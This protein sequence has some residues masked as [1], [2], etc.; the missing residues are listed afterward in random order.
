MKKFITILI[1]AVLSFSSCKDVD[2][3]IEDYQEYQEQKD[4]TTDTEDT[5]DT[6]TEEEETEPVVIIDIDINPPGNPEEDPEE[7]TKSYSENFNGTINEQPLNLTWQEPASIDKF[8]QDLA[9]YYC[10]TLELGGFSSWRLPTK[11]EL[12]SLIEPNLSPTINEIFESTS[13]SYY[14]AS[15]ITGRKGYL[16][17][18]LE[19]DTGQASRSVDF[20]VRCI[21]G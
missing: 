2:K 6:P 11:A 8:N 7:T 1:I 16:V 14:W 3:A 13:L 19:G 18:F 12:E 10:R 9:D 17:G 20:Y 21:S 5:E 4:A 15:E